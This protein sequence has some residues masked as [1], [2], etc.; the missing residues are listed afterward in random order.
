VQR[1]LVTQIFISPD[2]GAPMESVE[3][4][5]AITG[6]GL[7]GDRYFDAGNE[8]NDPSLEVTL[9]STEGIEAGRATDGLDLRPEDMR[10]NLM[11]EGVSLSS[12]IGRRFSVGEVQLEG[13]EENPPCAHL[14][15]LAGK[16]LLKPMIDNGGIRARILVSG[17][18]RVGDEIRSS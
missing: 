15:R 17:K 14:Q 8:G 2:A 9:F 16:P 11:T 1:G 4:I 13:L 7:E 3:E 18:I 5:G 12:L 6:K 10:R